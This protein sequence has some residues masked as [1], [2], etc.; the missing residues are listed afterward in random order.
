MRNKY[1]NEKKDEMNRDVPQASEAIP[2]NERSTYNRPNMAFGGSYKHDENYQRQELSDY[3]EAF[4]KLKEVTGVVDANEIIQKFKTQ[5]LTTQSL[6]EMQQN[7]A[8][9][10]E[11]LKDEK[12]SMRK[13]LENSKFVREEEGPERRRLDEIESELAAVTNQFERTNL[14]YGKLSG[15]MINIRAGVQHLRELTAF[16]K[17]GEE[18]GGSLEGDLK[19]LSEKLRRMYDVVKNDPNYTSQN[20]RVN[21]NVIQ[22]RLNES[23]RPYG[24]GSEDDSDQD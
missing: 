20:Y 17:V 4:R 6:E 23:R 14:K 10:I 12:E 7:Y 9:K 16:Y 13:Q 19:V 22:S 11:G 24:R 3:E 5:G 1:L 21:A 18:S 2:K 15:S 8:T